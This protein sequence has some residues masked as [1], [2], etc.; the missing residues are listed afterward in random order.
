MKRLDDRFTQDAQ[1][2]LKVI[3]PTAILVGGTIS[4]SDAQ[5]HSKYKNHD[6]GAKFTKYQIIGKGDI[7]EEKLF[8]NPVTKKHDRLYVNFLD[9]DGKK[10]YDDDLDIAALPFEET[11]PMMQLGSTKAEYLDAKGLFH[12]REIKD[13]NKFV[14]PES[15]VAN[16]C[17]DQIVLLANGVNPTQFTLAEATKEA[18]KFRGKNYISQS[19]T[20]DYDDTMPETSVLTLG[21]GDQ[22]FVYPLSK[23]QQEKGKGNHILIP[24]N[25]DNYWTYDPK[26]KDLIIKGTFY[27]AV[28]EGN[29]SIMTEKKGITRLGTGRLEKD[30]LDVD[31]ETKKEL[32]KQ[33][34]DRNLY[35]IFG[36]N[37]NPETFDG[38]NP[39]YWGI[40]FGFQKG[41]LS[42][43]MSYGK[44]QDEL[45]KEIK[46]EPNPITERYFHGTEI[47][48]NLN[49]LGL[50]SEL[51]LFN[52][53]R[54]SPFLGIGANYWWYNTE[55]S[56][57]VM[58]ENENVIPPKDY[59]E[60]GSEFS[61]KTNVGANV[62]LGKN[63]FGLTGG[64][65][66][67]AQFHSG[68][69]YA[70]QIGQR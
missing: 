54:V 22:Y 48:R 13:F 56:E 60:T 61:W 7:L 14:I 49:I 68:F 21:N 15:H 42:L 32:K 50:T 62:K 23:E 28:Y 52:S 12:Y 10:L 19:N 55:F 34:K 57:A 1:N 26:T 39:E 51:N 43:I 38:Q 4:E 44:A 16:R 66:S 37:T 30:T 29:P 27:R 6:I 41:P 64:F 35:L 45:I 18:N 25:N 53:K 65:D 11:F 8:Y 40:E 20:K 59:S 63:K 31:K 33:E 17:P 58:K 9:K 3:L 24:M 69:R 70:R 67:K 2:A 46:T 5:N 36:A 47:N